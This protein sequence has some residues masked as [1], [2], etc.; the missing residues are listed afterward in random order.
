M[1]DPLFDSPEVRAITAEFVGT[2]ETPPAREVEVEVTPEPEPA[3]ASKRGF[4]GAKVQPAPEP[5]Q[6]KASGFGKK[7]EAKV[8]SSSAGSLSDEIAALLGGDSDD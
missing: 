8:V 5:E 7:S 3:P 4:G 1:V 2:S 6:P